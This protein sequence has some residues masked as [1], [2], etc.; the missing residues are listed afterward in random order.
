M[1]DNTALDLQMYIDDAASMSL[2]DYEVNR[3]LFAK[4]AVIDVSQFDEM[5]ALTRTKNPTSNIQLE[6]DNGSKKSQSTLLIEIGRRLPMYHDEY[7]RYAKLY[8]DDHFE[9]HDLDSDNYREW[10]ASQYFQLT[11]KAT[12]GNGI[13]EAIETL[14]HFAK[15]DGLNR[16]MSLRTCMYDESILIDLTNEKFEQIKITK[17][18]HE[19][20]PGE[21]CFVRR[22]KPQ[23]LPYP[24]TKSSDIDLLWN[25]INVNDES[26]KKLIIGWII[27]ALY[28]TGPYPILVLQG[29]QGSCKSTATKII[30]SLVDPSFVPLS[31]NPKDKIDLI[32]EG[33]NNWVIA[34]DNLSY[35]SNETSDT[36]CR[37]STGGGIKVRR[38]YTNME[39]ISVNIQ[40]PIIINSI[41]EIVARGDLMERSIFVE[42]ESV[43][44]TSRRTEREIW[45]EFEIVKP[46]IFGALIEALSIA[47]LNLPNTRLDEKPRM[48]DFAILATSIESYFGWSEGS[49][50]QAYNRRHNNAAFAALENSLFGTAIKMLVTN[51]EDEGFIGIASEL[52]ES[53]N[54]MMHFGDRKPKGWPISPKSVSNTLRDIAPHLRKIGLEV[55]WLPRKKDRR[56]I[57]IFLNNENASSFESPSSSSG[58]ADDAGDN[59]SDW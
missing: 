48:A 37:I 34:L 49:F 33:R 23:S 19:I 51:R 58:D 53:L 39:E 14:K 45:M 57:H 38:L 24:D 11:E 13:K 12:Y 43:S 44:Q 22:G 29:E 26:D 25:F 30:R 4:N 27:A 21:S 7:G 50:L 6:D 28:P 59:D 20:I 55:E 2:E 56:E 54:N 32:T 3:D 40:R 47:L 36:L 10:L 46:K 41:N 52:E 15:R 9:I 42:L 1:E 31:D 5:V 16:S 35:I 8:V 17:E 18:S